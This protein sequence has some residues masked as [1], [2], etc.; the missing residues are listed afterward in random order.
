[1]TKAKRCAM[2]GRLPRPEETAPCRSFSLSQPVDTALSA[3]S[4]NTDPACA[5]LRAREA[6]THQLTSTTALS[7]TEPTTSVSAPGATSR[8]IATW[9]AARS[10][11]ARN[12]PS[13]P[14]EP[15]SRTRIAN[16]LTAWLWET[17]YHLESLPST[18]SDG[19]IAERN[20][21]C[22]AILLKKSIRR[23][24]EKLSVLME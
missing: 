9:P 24:P 18:D 11:G 23:T 10:R 6:Q 5:F 16:P 14:D 22:G 3:T 19:P 13:H 15:V 2:P 20:D 8:P 7:D 17:E 1:M 4:S 12:R 21:C